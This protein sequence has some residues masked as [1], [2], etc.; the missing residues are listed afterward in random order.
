MRH[1]LHMPFM[2]PRINSEYV[3][4]TDTDRFNLVARRRQR[5]YLNVQSC[6]G[7]PARQ[8]RRRSIISSSTSSRTKCGT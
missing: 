6:A 4:L 2:S 7:A 8:G 5:C 3:F 1:G